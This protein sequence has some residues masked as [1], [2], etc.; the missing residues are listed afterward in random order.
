[1]K[2]LGKKIGVTESAIGMYEKGRRKIDYEKL[3]MLAD[4]L[5]CQTQDIL[6]IE[7]SSEY[8]PSELLSLEE[9]D[10]VVA[11]RKASDK[12][13][14]IISNILSDY[15]MPIYKMPDLPSSEDTTSAVS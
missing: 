1:M 3:V 14:R 9:A 15:G 13:K 7:A 10:L 11:W 2:E 8:S 5:D 6:S 4:V 12:D